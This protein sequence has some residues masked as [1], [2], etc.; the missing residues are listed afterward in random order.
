MDKIRNKLVFLL[1]IVLFAILL[2]GSVQAES[3]QAETISAAATRVGDG[4]TLIEQARTLNGQEI[5]YQGE[6]VGD[7]MPRQDHYWIN[8]LSN[9][10]AIGIWITAEQRSIISL[11]GQYGVRGD[12]V[13]IAG[14]FNRACS[15]H[16][17][18]LDI[19]ARS[20]EVVSHGA[21][22]PQ[23][24]DLTRLIMA[25]GLLILAVS[26]LI[27]FIKSNYRKNP[28]ILLQQRQQGEQR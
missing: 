9:G 11:T 2:P 4:A 7:V 24:L 26:C 16:G 25:A 3:I 17:G 19:H 23:E 1:L 18:D 20:L 21:I 28:P 6:V 5:T 15:E 27:L 22:Q 12:E 10:T 14:L 8:V 13:K